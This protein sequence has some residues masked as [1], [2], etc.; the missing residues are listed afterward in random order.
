MTNEALQNIKMMVT[1]TLIYEITRS[2]SFVEKLKMKKFFQ[3]VAE[4]KK[5]PFTRNQKDRFNRPDSTRVEHI[6]YF[7]CTDVGRDQLLEWY[8]MTREV[9][10]AEIGDKRKLLVGSFPGLFEN[11]L[12]E[13]IN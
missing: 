5:P 7:K 10:S 13:I 3:K 4:D 12:T 11:M 2:F 8:E 1:V 6:T 9:D